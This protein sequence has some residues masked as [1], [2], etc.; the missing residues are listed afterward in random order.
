MKQAT[1]QKKVEQVNEVVEQFQNNQSAIVVNCIGLTVA[2]VMDLRRQLYA[3]GTELK[4][5]KNNVLRRAAATVGYVG[6]DEVLSGPSAVAFS[7]D[8]ANASKVIYDFAKKNKRLG[9]KAG[10]V[11]G[12]VMNVEEFK[13]FAT[14][15]NKEGMLSMLLSVLQ[16]PIRNLAY[17]VK[18]VAEQNL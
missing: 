14:L 7:N 13:V 4:V 2:E 1:L 10:V 3:K 12:K 15:P 16:A 11:D 6:L 5:I 8:A 9:V 18:S 17:A